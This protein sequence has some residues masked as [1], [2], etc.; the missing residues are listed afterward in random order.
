LAFVVKTFF[1][2]KQAMSKLKPIQHLA[3]RMGI[4]ITGGEWAM[5]L[6]GEERRNLV[7]YWFDGLFASASDT[8]PINYLTLYLL[9]LGATG[10]QVGLFTALTSL[11]AAACLLPGALLVERYGHR[12]E[13][14]VWF[15][16]GLA[17][18]ALLVLAFL[19]LGFTGQ[20]LIWIV[21][22]LA[23]IRSAA[24]NIAFPA[25]MSITGDIVPQEGR[26]R[27]FGSRNFVM[28]IA[29][30]LITYLVGEF[31]TRVGAP[32][33]YQLSLVLA[34]G[35][36]MISTYFFSSIKD[37][38]AGQPV[39]S[40]MRVSLPE[41]WKD[42]RASP[43]FLSFCF[44][45]ALW[46]FSIN[47]AGPFFNVYMVQNLNFTAAM[48]GLT[49]VATSITKLLIQRKVGEISDRWGHGRVQ[50][51]CMFIIPILPFVWIFIT[52]LWQVVV[53]N[54]VGGVMW[55][56]F[57]L[58]S[59]NFLLQLTPDAVRARYSAIFQIVVTVALAGGAA[60]GSSIILWWGY[61]GIFLVSALGRIVA[62]LFFLRLMDS[63]RQRD[64]AAGQPA[65]VTETVD[66]L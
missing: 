7:R 64:E 19:P 2:E 27:Y 47:V 36:G 40:S 21:I 1:R 26:G 59:F 38:H 17:R 54:L 52:Q 30:I 66:S 53:L 44:S 25:W 57:E 50:L 41:I 63:L 29:A 20:V 22:L 60:L 4:F 49:V 55:G 13:I 34:F 18:L 8:I 45:S 23:V 31:I 62:A 48:V 11:A 65:A 6:P 16:G 15:G 43:V 14:T 51:V 3:Q 35:V 5:S 9:A 46:N 24:G 12:K 10:S 32:Q 58:V 56:A 42:L 39:H 37:Q 28:G 33:G 61:T